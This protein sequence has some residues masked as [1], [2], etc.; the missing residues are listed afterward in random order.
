M[1]EDDL[2]YLRMTEDAQVPLKFEFKNYSK[3]VSE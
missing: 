3:A 2:L 1:D